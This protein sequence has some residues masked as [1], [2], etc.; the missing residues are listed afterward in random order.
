[1]DRAP[2]MRPIDRLSDIGS[3]HN[4]TQGNKRGRFSA[5]QSAQR[6]VGE[7]LGPP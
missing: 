1:M 7:R 5:A 6:R 3:I 4:E 2:V